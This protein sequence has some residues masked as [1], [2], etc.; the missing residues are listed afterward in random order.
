MSQDVLEG[1]V[2]ALQNFADVVISP[3]HSPEAHGNDGVRLHHGL[4]DMLM[5]Q[6]ILAR[7]IEDVD[8]R[9][10]DHCRYVEVFDGVHQF[11]GA[12][13]TDFPEGHLLLRLYDPIEV[14]P[15]FAGR[16]FGSITGVRDFYVQIV[17]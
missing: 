5:R 13:N 2:N 6:G 8:R 11:T 3:E 17:L 16:H 1:C 12:A 10:A 15:T 9:L 14:A 7:W 4:N